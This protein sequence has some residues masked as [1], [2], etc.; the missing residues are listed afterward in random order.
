M[1]GPRSV[2]SLIVSPIIQTILTTPGHAGKPL[3]FARTTSPTLLRMATSVCG[4]G[5]RSE[6]GKR[7][8]GESSRSE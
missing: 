8:R 1:S 2:Q 6:R 7:V 4:R 3:I 5:R